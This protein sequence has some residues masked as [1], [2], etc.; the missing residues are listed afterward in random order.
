MSGEPSK[1]GQLSKAARNEQ[2]KLAAAFINN[3]GVAVAFGGCIAPVLALLTSGPQLT[4][5]VFTLPVFGL[6]VGVAFHLFARTHLRNLV[7]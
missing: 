2:I 6:L 7:D 5:L 1:S 3:L 4:A